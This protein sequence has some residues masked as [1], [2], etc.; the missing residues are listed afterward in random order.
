M[1][2]IWQTM[3][4]RQTITMKQNAGYRGGLWNSYQIQNSILAAIIDFKKCRPDR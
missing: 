2:D 3:L 1:L 4:D